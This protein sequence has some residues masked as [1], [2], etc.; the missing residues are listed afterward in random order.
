MS[1]GAK[2]MVL[3]GYPA[4]GCRGEA[5]ASPFPA[6]RSSLPRLASRQQRHITSPQRLLLL[7][8][9]LQPL[10]TLPPSYK[11]AIIQATHARPLITPVKPL[12]YIG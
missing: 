7:R 8:R 1:H 11:G 4:E 5:I 6:P 10:T 3:A 12:S 2:A 9:R